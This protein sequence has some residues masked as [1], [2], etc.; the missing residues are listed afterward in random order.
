MK[1]AT[2]DILLSIC[3]A[4]LLGMVVGSAFNKMKQHGIEVR[5]PLMIF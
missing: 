2:K 5:I 3:F 4:V 1:K